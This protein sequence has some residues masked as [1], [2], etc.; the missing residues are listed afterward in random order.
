MIRDYLDIARPSH[1]VKNIFVL[2]GVVLA[3]FFDPR[4]LDAALVWRLAV[5]M[6]AAC[7]IASSNYVLNEILDAP[8]D[9]FHP[10]KKNRPVPSGR[11]SIPAAYAEWLLLAAAGFGLAVL[12]NRPFAS[13]CL[14]LWVM[15]IAYNVRPLRTKDRPYLDVLSESVNNPIR[16]A[17]GWYAAGILTAPTLSVLSAYWMFG[18]FLMAAK[19]FAE[20]RHIG[21]PQR[22]GQYRKSFVYYTEPRLVVSIV[23]YVTLF[24]MFSGV[25]ISRYRL[26]LLLATPLVALAMSRYMRIAYTDDSLVQN[27]ERIYRD[28]R[29]FLLVMSA[30]LACAV[31]LFVDVPAMRSFFLP[32]YPIEAADVSR[33]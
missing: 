2:P 6:A 3:A 1:W 22:A 4:I 11:V 26:E 20:Y 27:P 16:L 23:T 18:A 32:R 33:Q 5:G 7:L 30:F 14:A 24:G 13:S 25:F 19:R 8:S 12:I 28:R 15:G 21:D 10:E 31:L 17:M 29:L 9:R